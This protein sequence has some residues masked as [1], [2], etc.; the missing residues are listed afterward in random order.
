MLKKEVKELKERNQALEEEIE[1]MPIT[2]D[3]AKDNLLK[4]NRRLEKENKEYK[5]DIDILTS[6]L[7]QELQT[8]ESLIRGNYDNLRQLC[9]FSQVILTIDDKLIEHNFA[10]TQQ[11]RNK[12]PIYKSVEQE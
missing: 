6:D 4:K 1:K 2:G 9:D 7:R 10:F 11:K 5:R 8:N 12:A 3:I